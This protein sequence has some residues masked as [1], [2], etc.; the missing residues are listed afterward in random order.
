[1]PVINRPIADAVTVAIYDRMQDAT[2]G[3]NAL[4]NVLAPYYALDP[5]LYQVEDF[6]SDGFQWF[7]GS[8]SPEDIFDSS[9]LQ[10]PLLVLAVIDAKHG[11]SKRTKF[12]LFSGNVALEL[13]VTV[14]WPDERARHDFDTP[15]NLVEQI[16]FQMFNS[17]FPSWSAGEGLGWDGE[18]VVRRG[19][20][21]QSA[22]NWSQQLIATFGFELEVAVS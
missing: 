2:Y 12:S 22:E 8:V 4:V 19:A 6:S 18:L 11:G 5:D 10:Y 16:L 9:Q 1:V 21:I 20:V 15:A 7:T 17:H 3:W 14:T 13:S